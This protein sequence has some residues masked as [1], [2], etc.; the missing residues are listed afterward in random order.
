MR[1]SGDGEGRGV[2]WVG[3]R[4]QQ[5]VRAEVEGRKGKGGK[6]ARKE[7]MMRGSKGRKDGRKE[8][9]RGKKLRGSRRRRKNLRMR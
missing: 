5:V 8:A 6:Q 2:K 7:L 3:K 4:K 9:V 1:S